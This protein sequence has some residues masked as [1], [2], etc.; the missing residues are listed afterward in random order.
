MSR[1]FELEMENRELREK[2]EAL[3]KEFEEY[4]EKVR[5][6]LKN[7]GKKFDDLC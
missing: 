6:K 4:K 1:I 7:L 2:V 3:E 5:E